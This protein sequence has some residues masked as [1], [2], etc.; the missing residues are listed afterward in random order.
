MSCYGCKSYVE[1]IDFKDGV[2]VTKR[3]CKMKRR[4]LQGEEFV[5]GCDKYSIEQSKKQ[6]DAKGQLA[7]AKNQNA[8]AYVDAEFYFAKRR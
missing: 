8:D 6:A 1:M 5:N 7:D 3:K 2:G 4:I